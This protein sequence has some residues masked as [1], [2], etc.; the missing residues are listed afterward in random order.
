[1]PEVESNLRVF[2]EQESCSIIVLMGM[3][4]VDQNPQRGLTVVKVNDDHLDLYTQIIRDLEASDELQLEPVE[5]V[6]FLS[7]RVYQQRNVKG[8]RKQ[9]LPL[10]QEIVDRLDLTS[11]K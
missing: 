1:M 5:S 2:A 7:A 11:Y 3:K 8:S 4:V 9:V 10:V 6:E